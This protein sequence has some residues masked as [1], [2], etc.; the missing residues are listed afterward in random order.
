[1]P[2]H[3]LEYEIGEQ[4]Y[5]GGV[6]DLQAFEP[7]RRLPSAAVRGKLALVPVVQTAV[8]ELEHPLRPAGVG[9]GQGAAAGHHPYAQMRQLAGFGSHGV[10]DFPQRVETPDDGIKH[11]DQMLPSIEVLHVA[12]ATAFA[13]ELENFRLGHQVYQLSEHRLSEKMCTFA[14]RYSVL[15]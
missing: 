5:R 12:F 11:H 1:M 9:I 10:A 4:R 7:C 3:A 14:H 6:D 15:W 2:P 8:G 13:A